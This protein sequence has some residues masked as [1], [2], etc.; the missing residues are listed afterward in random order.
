[1]LLLYILRD[2]WPI[3]MISASHEQ[4]QQELESTLQ[5]PDCH[6]WWISKMLSGREDTLEK[7]YAIKFCFKLGKNAT[8]TYGMLQTAFRPSC[9]NRASVLEWHKE[10]R[11]S[12]RD[13]ERSGR[14]KEVRT[15]ELIGQIKN[16]L[17]EDRRVSIETISAQFDVNVRNVHTI[18]HEE[19]KM[20]KI[21]AQRR[22]ERKTLS[23]QQGDGWADQFRS[24]SSW[25][26]GDLR[27]K[28]DILLWPRDLE[29]EFPVEACWLSQ[30]KQIHPQTFFWQH[31][32]DLHALGSHW[33]DSQ[34]GILCWGF[35]RVQEEFPSEGASTQSGQGH[36]H[37]ENAPVHNSILVTDYLTKMDIKT[38]AHPP[39][40]P[41]LAPCDFY[42]FYKLKE[43]LRSCRYETIGEMKEAVTKVID[44]LT[45]ED[46]H[47]AFQKL[48]ERYNKCMQPEEITL[49]GTSF[50]CVLS[51]KV[52]IRKKS[53]NLFNEP[54]IWTISSCL[55]RMKKNWRLIQTIRINSQDIT[56]DFGLEKSAMLLI[57]SGK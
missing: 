9:M 4:L 2:D 44:T 54:C 38:V 55:S 49:K 27:W 18:I 16:F 19:L 24:R 35:K 37:Q 23:W 1:M 36:F 11:E 12:V 56:M 52:P 3:F 42:L 34:Q 8:E 41:D 20:R 45:Q 15:L 17:D 29:T 48:L 6:S 32:H 40:C 46:F 50:M 26:S 43:K 22:S 33:T 21:C 10:G 47:G 57:K 25:C 53:G 31:W 14:S 51:I 13:D 7:R 39:Y 30:T 5:K 28:L